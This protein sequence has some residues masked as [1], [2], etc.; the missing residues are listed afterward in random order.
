MTRN[1]FVVLLLLTVAAI[2]V[3]ALVA[4]RYAEPGL[5]RTL[6]VAV[7]AALVVFPA[8]KFAERRG[9]I[10][11]ELDFS[12]MGGRASGAADERGDAK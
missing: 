11:G 2:G 6:I 10:R 8:A 1:G 3:G 12:K 5:G 4:E 9:W 7:F